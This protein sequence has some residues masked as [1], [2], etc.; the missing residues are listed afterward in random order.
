MLLDRQ[1]A[2]TLRLTALYRY[3]VLALAVNTPCNSVIGGGGGIMLMAGLSG[4]FSPLAVF[5]TMALAV[6]P[7]PFALVFLGLRI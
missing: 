5:A 6:S 4:L 2:R 3:V 7:V 1:S